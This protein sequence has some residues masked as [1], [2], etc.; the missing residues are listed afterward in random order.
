MSNCRLPI[1]S[2]EHNTFFHCTTTK[3]ASDIFQA[4][5]EFF[6]FSWVL[7]RAYKIQYLFAINLCFWIIYI[8]AHV[9]FIFPLF[10]IYTSTP[11]KEKFIY[12]DWNWTTLIRVFTDLL[13]FK[14]GTNLKTISCIVASN[15]MYSS[16]G[17]I[18]ILHVGHVFFVFKCMTMQLLQTRITRIVTILKYLVLAS[19]GWVCLHIL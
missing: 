16:G 7:V 15:L 6:R 5:I 4:H 8:T 1:A 14:P 17:W 3:I 11:N 12:N 13:F 19:Y 2:Y 18:M 10:F 9:K